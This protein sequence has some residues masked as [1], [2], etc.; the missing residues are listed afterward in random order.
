MWKCY[1]RTVNTV[2]GAMKYQVFMLGTQLHNKTG[3]LDTRTV[4]QTVLSS[5]PHSSRRN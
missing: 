2:C 5:A 4:Q 1:L 3:F